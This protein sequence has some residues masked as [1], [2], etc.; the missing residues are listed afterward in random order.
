MMKQTAWQRLDMTARNM[1][2]FLLA[3]LFILVGLVPTHVPDFVRISPLLSLAAVYHWGV[4]RPDLMPSIAVFFLGVFQDLLGGGPF[5]LHALVLL[6]TYGMLLT[7][8]RFFY[9]KSFMVIWLG[10]AIVAAGSVVAYWVIACL[11]FLKLLPPD[12]FF[13]QYLITLA[14]FPV[15]SWLLV[16]WQ[17]MV[18][19]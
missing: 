19:R 12:S 6:V 9:G 18:L 14:I 4:Y 5:G 13:F 3:I 2:P 10:F 11:Y 8:R 15:I 1:T 16:R 17:R 7:Q